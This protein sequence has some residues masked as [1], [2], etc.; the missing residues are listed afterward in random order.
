MNVVAGSNASNVTP[1]SVIP[2]IDSVDGNASDTDDCD[3]EPI[4]SNDDL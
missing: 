4:D 3:C 2:E 1:K